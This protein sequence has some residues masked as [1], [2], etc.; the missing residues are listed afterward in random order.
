MK[1]LILLLLIVSSGVVAGQR[2]TDRY[3]RTIGTVIVLPDGKQVMQDKFGR[4]TGMYSPKA[5]PAGTT[6]DNYG[7]TIGYGNQLLLTLPQLPK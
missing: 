2:L 3:G 5:G 6:Y 1:L 4:S 7:R